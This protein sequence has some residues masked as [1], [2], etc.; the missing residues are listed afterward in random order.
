MCGIA[1]F[2]G[3]LQSRADGAALLASMC[4]TLRRRGP[5][6]DGFFHQEDVGLGMRRLSII[7]LSGGWQPIYNEDRTLTVVFNGEIYNYA[8]LRADLLQR[9]HTFSTHSDTETLVHG[10]E[11]WGDDFPSHLRGMFAFALWDRKRRRLLLGRDR[12]G[13]KPLYYAIVRQTLF[14]ASEI[15]ALL[16]VPEI[17]RRLSLDAV[18]AYLTF[19]Y[20][21]DPATIYEEIR[22]IPPGEMMIW[23]EGKGI[24]KPY[25]HLPVTPPPIHTP[26]EWKEALRHHLEEAVRL[27]MV[28]DVPV[29]VFLSG[30]I[31]SSGILGLVARQQTNPIETFSIGFE[32][33]AFFDE[34]PFAKMVAA[35]YRT[36]HHEFVVRPDV[37]Q[38]LPDLIEA[39]DQPFADSSAIPTYYVSQMTRQQVK[40]A[41]SGLGGDELFGG[42]ERYRGGLMAARFQ[43]IPP[44]IRRGLMAGVSRLPDGGSS[45]WTGRIKRF[46]ASTNLTGAAQ[47]LSM[48]AFFSAEA[49]GRLIAP[50]ALSGERL[51]RPEREAAALF[52]SAADRPLLDKMLLF[53][54]RH[55]LP[56][57]LLTLTDRIGM[58]H[59]LEVRPPFLDHVL[60]TFAMQIPPELKIR[61]SQTKSILKSAL[62]DLIPAPLLHRGKRGFSVPLAGWLRK[63]LRDVV[64]H[65]LG[66]KGLE[67]L[68]FL[69][70]EEVKKIVDDHQAGRNNHESRIWALLILS[71]WREKMGSAG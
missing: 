29:G 47:Y 57:D 7:D 25:W 6:G 40:V 16:Q 67:R 50:D 33:N 59:S 56:G 63:E 38:I 15:K 21:P 64:D 39:F 55:Y 35:R 20:I 13:I 48:I 70:G 9:G 44:G 10:Y 66:R 2:V 27:H 51:L 12:I 24:V 30:G 1:G 69:N 4:Q 61:G 31:D 32:G 23:E 18:N 49:R 60:L 3:E 36:E 14:F 5:D 37:R 8:A 54:Q 26:E 53:D 45:P 19:G 17:D 28:S 58:F 11:T 43:S 65:H 46:V 71:A 34:R 42:Y 41:L 62:A 52:D 22:Q 68:P